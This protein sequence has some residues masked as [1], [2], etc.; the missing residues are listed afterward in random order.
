MD[1]LISQRPMGLS[2][3]TVIGSVLGVCSLFSRHGRDGFFVAVA[4]FV[5]QT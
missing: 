5:D 4:L 2:L 1:I 3:R